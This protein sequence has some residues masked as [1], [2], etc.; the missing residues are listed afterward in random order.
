MSVAGEFNSFVI[1]LL[2]NVET[3][4]TLIKIVLA[5]TI[6]F[7][8]IISIVF[9][10]AEENKYTILAVICFICIILFMI[11][12]LVYMSFYVICIDE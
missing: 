2:D 9:V 8:I 1:G 12:V 5:P 4:R 6:L 3:R 11:I 10:F 7:G